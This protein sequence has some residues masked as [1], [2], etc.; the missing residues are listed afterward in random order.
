MVVRLKGGDPFV[1]GRGGEE[2]LACYAAGVP[3]VVIPGVSSAIAVP[4]YA[5]IPVTQRNITA[6]FTVF[7]A[8]ED[9]NDEANR[10]D[11]AALARIGGT[12][13]ALMGVSHLS[14]VVE[15]LLA[16]G[17]NPNTP[18]ACVEWGTTDKQRVVSGTLATLVRRVTDANIQ[19]PAIT[20]IGEVVR[21]REMGLDWFKP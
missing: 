3:F 6:A 20:I 12:L 10:I 19:P 9:P 8:H 11:Y 16:A 13:V 14:G 7:S 1:F 15:R 5:G 17:I 4:A 21:L 2:A 18:A